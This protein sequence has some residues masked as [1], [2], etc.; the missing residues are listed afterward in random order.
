MTEFKN[1]NWRI[2][3]SKNI[4]SPNFCLF[5]F[6][7]KILTHKNKLFA[8]LQKDC[9]LCQLIKFNVA[10]STTDYIALGSSQSFNAVFITISYNIISSYNSTVL[11]L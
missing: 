6:C 11:K 7:Q 1:A 3:F 2:K 9:H 8:V 4:S 5:F 10:H